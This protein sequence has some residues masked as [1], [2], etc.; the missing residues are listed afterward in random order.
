MIDFGDL[1]HE[2]GS[3]WAIDRVHAEWM[4]AVLRAME[5]YGVIEIGCH[6]G[7]STTAI[8]QAHSE[9]AVEEVHLIDVLVQPTVRRLARPGVVIHECKSVD[10]LPSINIHDVAVVIDGD[11]RL[12]CVR[13][14]L[15]LVLAMHP[16]VIMAHDVSAEAA[17]YGDCDGSRWLWEELQRQGWHCAVDCRRRA[18]SRTHRG[19]LI[20]TRSIPQHSVVLDAWRQTCLTSC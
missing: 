19:F 9:G 5:P 14:E 12:S 8:M 7:V 16:S 6:K 1:E 15:P 4:V 11:H 18:N 3:E 2:V 10:A 20:A 17:G 13:E